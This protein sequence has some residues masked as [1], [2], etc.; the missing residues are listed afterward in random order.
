VARAPN[1]ALWH[2]PEDPYDAEN[3]RTSGRSRHR[4]AHSQ[5]RCLIRSGITMLNARLFALCPAPVDLPRLRYA[6]P[7][8]P[9]KTSLRRN[10]PGQTLR[11]PAHRNCFHARHGQAITICGF[12]SGALNRPAASAGGRRSPARAR[13]AR[14]AI[15]DARHRASRRG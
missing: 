8:T 13:A 11:Q 7:Q 6:K 9:A 4:P 2:L 12:Q 10:L 14:V 15:R 3:V 5:C 1:V